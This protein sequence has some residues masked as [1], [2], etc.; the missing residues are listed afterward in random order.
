MIRLTLATVLVLGMVA[1]ATVARVAEPAA[2]PAAPAARPKVYALLKDGAYVEGTLQK[3]D[4]GV[5]SV[6]SEGKLRTFSENDVR[7]IAFPPLA[8]INTRRPL[9]RSF[10]ELIVELRKDS[11]SAGYR[12]A[13]EEY[14]SQ[15]TEGLPTLLDAVAKDSGGDLSHA[16]GSVLRAMGREA[17]PT[18]VHVARERRDRSVRSAV[19]AAL[20]E[21]EM[22]ALP[23]IRDLMT[24]Q[25]AALREMAMS[26]L[27]NRAIQAATILPAAL[28]A[29]LIVTSKDESLEVRKTAVQ[30][31]GRMGHGSENI[32]SALTNAVE[33]D[34]SWQVSTHAISALAMVA[35]QRGFNSSSADAIA[36]TIA[37]TVANHSAPEVRASAATSL[38]QWGTRADSA[39]TVL[40]TAARDDRAVVVREAAQSTLRHIGQAD[41][42]ELEKL[43]VK[44]D[45][46]KLIRGMLIRPDYNQKDLHERQTNAIAGLVRAG[47]ENLQALMVVVRKD[48]KSAYWN[49]VADVMARWGKSAIPEF[50]DYV[51]DEHPL[52]R[53]AVAHALG[54]M[55][56]EEMPAFLPVLLDDKDQGV[57]WSAIDSIVEL[58]KIPSGEMQ[59]K[60][61]KLIAHG[62]ADPQMH[63]EYWRR[64]CRQLAQFV[65]TQDEALPALLKI[66]KSDASE[67]HRST[68]IREL[69]AATTA[70]KKDDPRYVRIFSAITVALDE[71]MSVSVKTGALFSLESMA[72]KS[73]EAKKLLKKWASDPNENVARVARDC[74][75][76]VEGRDDR[77]F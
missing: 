61:V 47:P 11:R 55:P 41:L 5:Y 57:R 68:V 8:P 9:P 52:V 35:Q 49:T 37:K 70:M 28:E 15:G 64:A 69:G 6:E 48:E 38:A 74:L 16:A 42:P 59:K 14:A 65:P 36:A 30:I 33:N 66:L 34:G 31:L 46:M 60:S 62:L 17:L 75:A 4:A 13:V 71:D 58:S 19:Q 50:E 39:A 53:R 43:G 24:D 2:A 3:F 21:F 7:S 45:A 56:V 77:P 1:W 10:D 76:R 32:V 73:D 63:R 29:P 20:A 40:R 51:Y 44:D 18:L 12:A 27:Y 26:L 54:K 72:P 67:D 22:D 23:Q 25:D